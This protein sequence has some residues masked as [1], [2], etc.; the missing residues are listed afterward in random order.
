M[1]DKKSIQWLLK[2]LPDLVGRG[3]LNQQTADSLRSHYAK[4]AGKKLGLG[5]ILCSIFA[6]VL[7]GLGI[8]LLFGHNWDQLSRATRAALSIG[9]LLGA[10]LLGGW[11][12][13]A[14]SGSRAWRES[15]GTFL[16]LCVGASIALIGQT[17]H[18][19]GNLNQYLLTWM[20]LSAPIIYLFAAS[21]P[22]ILYLI[23]ITAWACFYQSVGE[24]A[25]LFWP[26]FA[27]FAGH[28]AM[29]LKNDRYEIDSVWVGWTACICLS[30]GLGVSLEKSIPGLWTIVYACFFA[31][32]HMAGG[33]WFS[34][35]ET[36]WRKPFHTFGTA[37]SAILVL[38]LTFDWP[39]E[40][41]GFAYRRWG[42]EYHQKA[43][44]IDFGLSV[45]LTSFVVL[46][47]LDVFR[48]KRRDLLWLGLAPI[49]VLSA[50]LLANA[51]TET[52]LIL[53]LTN[54]Y[55]LAVSVRTIFDGIQNNRLGVMNA[56]MLLLAFLLA[57]RF[58]D[59]QM[60]FISR[61]LAFIAIGGGFLAANLLFARRRK[62]QAP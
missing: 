36:R 3:V 15:S 6:S 32:L 44:L 56:G 2:E 12:L 54:V 30:V 17:Y 45:V 41:V 28:L 35:T 9:L 8:I 20:L 39:W 10:Q 33:I 61:G 24:Q 38:L 4:D 16:M 14:K 43:A 40:R 23:G 50:Y 60:S 7:I 18:I 26:L 29:I 55:L 58:F 52:W 46:L 11:V 31:C 5:L 51:G 25:M 1:S 13:L 48:K 42:A 57:A 53:I 21:L 37:A 19:P 47:L 22:A 62:V 34:G 49:V 59:V 27:F